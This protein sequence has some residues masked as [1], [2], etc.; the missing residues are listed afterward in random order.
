MKL[1]TLTHTLLALALT[2]T[3]YA[4]LADW[5]LNNTDS[6]LN[7]ISIKK[8]SIG[9]VNSFKKLTGSLKENGEAQVTVNLNSVETR[10][11][12]R[13]QRIKKELFETSLFPQ[14]TVKTK[15]N[16]KRINHLKA[17]ES[18][19]EVLELALSIHGQQQEVE[20]D[21][22]ITALT[23]NKLLAST[24]KPIIIKASDFKLVQ[25]IEVLRT[26]A[27]LPSISTAIPVTASFIF[28][29]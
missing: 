25:G 11:A 7:F 20:A 21:M 22:R 6:S 5:N 17:G 3:S 16:M 23:G 26:L 2:T 12:K 15:L 13:N 10:V 28:A 4:T 24:I 19:S 27:K 29:R 18:Y 9:E 1:T 14:A 8:Q